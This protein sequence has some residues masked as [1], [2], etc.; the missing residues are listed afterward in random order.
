MSV[1]KKKDP[2]SEPANLQVVKDPNLVPVLK[3]HLS[4]DCPSIRHTVRGYSPIWDGKHYRSIILDR[5][6][7]LIVAEAHNG[8]R[9]VTSAVG[10]ILEMPT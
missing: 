9:F 10:C 3:V 5:D 7:Q 2:K 1:A 4:R 8:A 6:R